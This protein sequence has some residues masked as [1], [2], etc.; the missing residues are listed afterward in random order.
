M[1]EAG[2]HFSFRP[3][4]TK[5]CIIP[6]YSNYFCSCSRHYWPISQY[7]QVTH[8]IYR[9]TAASPLP[10]VKGGIVQMPKL[11]GWISKSTYYFDNFVPTDTP[12]NAETPTCRSSKLNGR[13]FLGKGLAFNV[14]KFTDPV[15]CRRGPVLGLWRQLLHPHPRP[16]LPPFF[17]DCR[18]SGGDWI[19]NLTY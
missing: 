3:H 15:K 8:R 10:S 14:A 18:R 11:H 16:S 1:Y 9:F 2:S 5:G 4:I 7:V 13:W 19:S 12:M 17:I 6:A